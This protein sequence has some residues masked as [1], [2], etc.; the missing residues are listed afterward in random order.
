MFENSKDSKEYKAK[1]KSG[2]RK[3]LKKEGKGLKVVVLNSDKE[4][5]EYD[6]AF[7]KKTYKRRRKTKNFRK[8]KKNM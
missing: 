5:E 2:K 3:I 4:E 7:Q 8:N 6:Q 1:K